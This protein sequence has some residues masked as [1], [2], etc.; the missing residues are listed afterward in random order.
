V[1]RAT[2]GVESLPNIAT[3]VVVAAGSA[4]RRAYTSLYR[5]IFSQ[6]LWARQPVCYCTW[7]LSTGGKTSPVVRCVW[8]TRC[9]SS[10]R[11]DR[12]NNQRASFRVHADSSVCHL[13]GCCNPAILDPILS[14]LLRKY[15]G[16]RALRLLDRHDLLISHGSSIFF[17]LR[18]CLLSCLIWT[19][20]YCSNVPIRPKTPGTVAEPRATR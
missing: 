17:C 13:Q 2:R 20:G 8:K 18:I 11:M 15:Y 9:E 6:S 4:R 19:C 5:L 16:W 10:Q 1:S 14:R 12:W 7:L 3:S